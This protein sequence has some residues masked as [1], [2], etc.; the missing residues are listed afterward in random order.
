VPAAKHTT[1][2]T[3]EVIDIFNDPLNASDVW[4]SKLYSNSLEH[5]RASASMLLLPRNKNI[6][7]HMQVS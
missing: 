2:A 6:I 7:M 3:T 1:P 4:R 5:Y